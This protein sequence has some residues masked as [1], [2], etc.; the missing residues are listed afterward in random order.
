MYFISII[1][2]LIAFSISVHRGFDAF[3]TIGLHNEIGLSL[4]QLGLYGFS[5]I[6]IFTAIFINLL[7]KDIVEELDAID[8]MLFNDKKTDSGK[9]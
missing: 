2:G 6:C 7:V 8:A 1:S 5:I 4:L 9:K 3:T